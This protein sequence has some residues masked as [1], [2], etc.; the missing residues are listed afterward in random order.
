MS[1]RTL[2]VLTF[3][4]FLSACLPDDGSSETVEEQQN[5]ASL[6]MCYMKDSTNS[7]IEGDASM[8]R[9]YTLA[10]VSKVIT[11]MW[12]IERLGLYHRYSTRIY[13]TPVGNN[14]FDMHLEGSRDPIMGQK[15]AY[16]IV[17]QLNQ[18]GYDT[19]KI[20]TLS[21]DE[22]F[23]F[24]WRLEQVD[25]IKGNTE[26]FKNRNDQIAS[27]ARNLRAGFAS[28]DYSQFRQL[29]KEANEDGIRLNDISR[30]DARRVEFKPKAQFFK[31]AQTRTF[32]YHSSPL[33]RILKNMN[34][35]SNNYIAD[36]IY[37]NLGSSPE[38][39]KYIKSSM[40]FGPETIQFHLGSGNNANYIDG[41]SNNIYNTA[42][43][44]AIIKSMLKVESL[45]KSE[46][47]RLTDILPVAKTDTPSTLE[48]Y[49]GLFDH[50]M[51]AKTGTVNK[52]KTLAGAVSTASGKIYF[53]ALYEAKD[54]EDA[55]LAVGPI[56]EK[57][58]ELIRNNGGPVKL[59]YH[60]LNPLPFDRESA[61]T[62]EFA[63]DQGLR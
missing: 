40:G 30:I 59:N 34:N 17:S 7:S 39:K 52:A 21:F 49:V 48:D 22:N 32:V 45:L 29:Q 16:F 38:F 20:E 53:A 26:F 14:A 54:K 24:E 13:I 44:P 1:L 12:A 62:E 37:W 10:S 61:L 8:S 50:A 6:S 2:L 28:L 4:I 55:D 19:G 42:T 46:R 25:R 41:N 31:T 51:V 11:S 58:L 56:K 15:A 57:V 47:L 5:E 60:K 36:H 63:L 33:H 35:S 18:L 23:L 43:C 3:P 27:V 9:R